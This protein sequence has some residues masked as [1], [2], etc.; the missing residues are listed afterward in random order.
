MSGSSPRPIRK[1]WAAPTPVHGIKAA[2]IRP[3]AAICLHHLVI[4]I[5]PCF[6]WTW[7]SPI[8]VCER[9]SQPKITLP[10]RL[11]R[12]NDA[13]ERIKAGGGNRRRHGRRVRGELVAARRPQ[14][15]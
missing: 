15:L 6:R 13:G 10:V 14:R 8:V 4:P 7:D 2:A 1:V 9:P 5:S 12:R 11:G 3:P